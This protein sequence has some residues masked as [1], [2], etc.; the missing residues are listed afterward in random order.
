MSDRGNIGEFED[1]PID[2]TGIDPRD[3]ETVMAQVGASRA[4]AVKA[5]RESGGDLIAAILAA[6][7]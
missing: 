6:S 7:E 1:E 5:L 2:D 3:I 4:R